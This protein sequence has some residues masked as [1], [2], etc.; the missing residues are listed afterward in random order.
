MSQ[1]GAQLLGKMAPSTFLAAHWQKKP[2]L[3][4]QAI[5][6]FAGFVDVADLVRFARKDDVVARLVSTNAHKKPTLSHGPF[7]NLDVK[8]LRGPW[9]LLVQGVEALHPAGWELLSRFDFL[10]RARLDDLMISHASLGGGVGPHVDKYDVF[11]LQGPGRRRWRIAE[12]GSKSLDKR[13]ALPTLQQFVPEQEWV[14]DPGDMLYLPPGVAHEGVAVDG[15]CFT[16]SIGAVAPSHEALVQ[17][18]LAYKSQA[19]SSLLDVETM[20]EDPA[21]QVPRDPHALHAAMTADVK[22]L[23]EHHLHIDDRDVAQFLGRLL[24]GPKPNVAWKLPKKKATRVD[25]ERA[26]AAH[27]SLPTRA[28]IDGDAV[29]LNGEAHRFTGADVDVV[30]ALVR[31]R[32]VVLT[33]KKRS[34]AIT[35]VIVGWVNAGFV[36]LS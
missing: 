34:A 29:F 10:P 22:R 14:L 11:L 9:S 31:A 36:K 4:R 18:Y 27:F 3:I 17:N 19:L 5:P 12:G 32:N 35:D 26:T 21:L 28:L 1:T 8:T 25:V 20:L 7:D 30:H 2:L 13:S 33:G 23:L 15:A 24:T 16:Y 6:Q